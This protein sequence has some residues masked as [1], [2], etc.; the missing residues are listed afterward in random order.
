MLQRETRVGVPISPHEI[1]LKSVAQIECATQNRTHSAVTS[2]AS[3]PV[4]T[5]SSRHGLVTVCL[6]D[7]AQPPTTTT[8]L[9]GLHHDPF[10]SHSLARLLTTPRAKTY[11]GRLRTKWQFRICFRR[12]CTPLFLPTDPFH[13]F[14]FAFG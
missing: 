8:T 3:S 2:N 14:L 9:F 4:D 7:R 13:R 6:H 11:A 5:L 1:D 10:R 12:F